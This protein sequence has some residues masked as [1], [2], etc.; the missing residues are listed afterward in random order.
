MALQADSVVARIAAAAGA[1]LV[2]RPPPSARSAVRT[3]AA[4][5]GP[6]TAELTDVEKRAVLLDVLRRD[7]ALFLGMGPGRF[8]SEQLNRSLSASLSRL[9]AAGG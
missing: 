9:A 4:T 2:A 3:D 8:C 7:P 6:D 1:A 5:V